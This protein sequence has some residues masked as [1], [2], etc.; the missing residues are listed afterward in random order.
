MRRKRGKCAATLRPAPSKNR[1]RFTREKYLYPPLPQAEIQVFL[2]RVSLLPSCILLKNE[3]SRVE[4]SAPCCR[5]RPLGLRLPS[6]RTSPF[7]GGYPSSNRTCRFPAYGSPCGTGFIGFAPLRLSAPFHIDSNG[8]VAHPLARRPLATSL[9]KA[10]CGRVITSGRLRR[11][12][13]RKDFAFLRCIF[14]R[15]A[16]PF[17]LSPRFARSSLRSAGMS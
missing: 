13:L 16:R 17:G 3:M 7:F 1:Q 10:T 8:W 4:R 5:V 9:R 11:G 12:P 15:L 2:L 6:K 14:A